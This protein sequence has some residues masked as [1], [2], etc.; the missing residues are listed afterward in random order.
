MQF[1][2]LKSPTDPLLE[3]WLDL[4]QTAFPMEEQVLVSAVL[5]AFRQEKQELDAVLVGESF[6]GLTWVERAAK[7]AVLWYV[8]IAESQRRHGYGGRVLELLKTRAKQ[9]GAK[10]LFLEVEQPELAPDPELARRRIAFYQRHGGLL[11]EGAAYRSRTGWQPDIPMHLIAIPLVS[12][13]RSHD[14][15]VLLLDAF[16]GGLTHLPDP[17]ILVGM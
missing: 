11:I 10:V 1:H 5:R 4:Y 3:P 8:A 2:H 15:R 13:L 7:Y 9:E 17:L 6:L 16:A 12:D 14:L